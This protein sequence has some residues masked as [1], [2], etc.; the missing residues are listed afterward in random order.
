MTQPTQPTGAAPEP[1][2]QAQPSFVTS[3]G[4]R[5]VLQRL[6]R[7]GP[8]AWRDD[9]EAAALLEYATRRYA[10]L[11][12]K[13]GRDPGDAAVAAFEVMRAEATRTARDPWAVV[14]TAVRRSLIAEHRAEGLLT[15]AR[16]ARR[17]SYSGFHDAQRFGERDVDSCGD[18]CLAVPDPADQ[19]DTQHETDHGWLVSDATAVLAAL[20][21]PEETAALAVGW[22]CD[23]LADIGDRWS[24]YEALRRDKAVR[25]RLGVSHGAWI[26]LLRGLLGH[27]DG[28]GPLRHGLLAR[29]LA[30]D[31]PAALAADKHVRY[32]LGAQ[33]ES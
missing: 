16:R 21:W 24:A 6:H 8:G 9:A 11:A 27:P 29:L 20:G 22:V 5:A 25:A 4:L 18:P 32:Q 15:S 30:G 26:A 17:W 2:G 12:R 7:A 33:A 10:A 31:P 14:T 13:Y 3:E 23:R 28:A 19:L 1:A